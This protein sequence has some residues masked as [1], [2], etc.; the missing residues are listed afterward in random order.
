MSLHTKPVKAAILDFMKREKGKEGER[1]E[2]RPEE[3][4]HLTRADRA[5]IIPLTKRKELE[6]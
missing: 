2:G 4:K 3:A 5:A 6:E 1:E